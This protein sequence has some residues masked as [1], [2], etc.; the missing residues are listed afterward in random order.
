[1]V[2]DVTFGASNRNTA[3]RLTVSSF[4]LHRKTKSL[5]CLLLR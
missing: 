2:V 1:V 3:E 4:K 5:N